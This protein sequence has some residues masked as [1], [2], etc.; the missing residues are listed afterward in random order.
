MDNRW[1]E[2][3]ERLLEFHKEWGHCIVPF[4]F[5]ED[6]SLGHWVRRQRRMFKRG[7]LRP[8]RK[9]RLEEVEFEF[10]PC[11]ADQ[12]LD[13]LQWNSMYQHLVEYKA[14]YVDT[15]VKQSQDD[16]GLQ[17]WVLRQRRNRSILNEHRRKLLDDIGLRWTRARPRPVPWQ[18]RFEELRDHVSSHETCSIK[19][20]ENPRLA[21]WVSNQK[22]RIKRGKLSESQMKKLESIVFF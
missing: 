3:Y 16:V 8:D 13:D 6:P 12:N 19:R 22:W 4:F 18:G 10:D 9:D 20:N 21:N 7:L 5:E 2:K 1:N 15:N 11:N 14:T 17:M